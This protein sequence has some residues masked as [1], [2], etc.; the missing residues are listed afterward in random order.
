MKP[1]YLAVRNVLRN[2]RRTFIT[3]ASI[4]LSL[5]ALIFIWS[6]IDGINEQMIDNSTRYLS[7]HLQIHQRGYHE[8]PVLYRS[9]VDDPVLWAHL[10]ALPDVAGLAPR[11]EGKALL[12]GSDKSR[13]VMV[14]GVDPA[15]EPMVT[16]STGPLWRGVI[17]APVTT[18]T[19]CWATRPQRCWA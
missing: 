5:A 13:L 6:S 19:S 15:L 9:M 16:P 4:S 14:V 7:S 1:L 2:V 10:R 12:S 3:L 17:C 18:S 8:D 11:V